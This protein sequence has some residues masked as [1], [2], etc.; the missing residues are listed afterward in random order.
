M[1]L[2]KKILCLVF[3]S[4]LLGLNVHAQ[5]NFYVSAS[6]DDSNSGTLNKP[7]ASLSRALN[8]ARKTSGTVVVYILTGTY[9]LARPI[10]FTPADSR[11]EN[12]SLTIINFKN[13]K[14]TISGSG[15]VKSKMGKI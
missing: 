14:V 12:E 8:E 6:G 13:Q 4:V 7:F 10:I 5:T 3:T 2:T 1:E 9:Y 11:K 15:S